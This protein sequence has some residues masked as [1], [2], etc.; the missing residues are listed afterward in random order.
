MNWLLIVVLVLLIGGTVAGLIKGFTETIYSLIAT[1]L[2]IVLTIVLCPVTVKVLQNSAGLNKT[3]YEKLDGV[4]NLEEAYN[5]A[6]KKMAEEGTKDTKTESGIT[7]S[8]D[9]VLEQYGLPSVMRNA[10]TGSEDF[11]KYLSTSADDFA[12]GKMAPLEEHV[13]KILTNVVINA[14]GFVITFIVVSILVFVVG[15]ILDLISK[16]PGLKQ[17]NSVLGAAAGF[18]E[19]LLV[20]WIVFMIITLISSTEL[21]Q[22]ALKLINDSKLL[23]FIYENNFISKKIFALIK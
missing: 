13:C 22:S 17:L 23:S 1:A 12:R 11:K 20:I 15:K 8:V 14:I 16:I 5:N 7:N 4:I 19:A 10:I 2:I 9:A 18:A 6:M 3:I 21:G